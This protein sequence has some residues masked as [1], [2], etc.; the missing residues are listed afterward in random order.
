MTGRNDFAGI[1]LEPALAERVAQFDY[2]EEVIRA[3]GA[4][5]DHN[6]RLLLT[7]TS[8]EWVGDLD[9]TM[10]TVTRNAPFQVMHATGL[11]VRGWDEM[12]D[13]YATRLQTFQGQGFVPHRWVVSDSLIVGNG[14]FSGT[15][16]G[17]FFGIQTAGKTL[18]LPM[19]VW[20]YFEDGLI[21]GEAAY[22]DGHELRH[23]IVNGTTRSPR[24][25]VL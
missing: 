17:V 3:G 25:P 1:A 13:F 18:C 2:S 5:A 6:W 24:D 23:Q 7:H 10:A 15:P 4:N 19:T 21:K 16:S 22:L 9:G 14:Y 8:A 20:I 12:R 11:D